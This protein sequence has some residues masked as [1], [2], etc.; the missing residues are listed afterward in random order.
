[1]WRLSVAALYT[2]LRRDP[3]RIPAGQADTDLQT[4]PSDHTAWPPK[5]PTG[6]EKSPRLAVF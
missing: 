6:F 3:G 5:F 2:A 1:L 4:V